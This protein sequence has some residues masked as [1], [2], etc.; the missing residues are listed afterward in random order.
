MDEDFRDSLI[1]YGDDEET[2]LY[3]HSICYFLESYGF[4]MELK[5]H[6][7]HHLTDLTWTRTGENAENV[8]V[9]PYPEL[10]VR[11]HQDWGWTLENAHVVLIASKL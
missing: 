5:D 10:T 6:T 2:L 4:C 11:R 7:M 1:P 3:H 8:R 9:G